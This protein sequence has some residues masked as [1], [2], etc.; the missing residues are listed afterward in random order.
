VIL[1][2]NRA[3]EIPDHIK[4]LIFDCDGT[5]VDS[6]SLHMEAWNDALQHFGGV[7]DHDFF[8]SKKG[9]K[10]EEIVTLYNFQY[11]TRY[12]P[13][14]IV[15]AKHIFFWRHIHGVKPIEKI[16]AVVNRFK[17]LLPLA[18]VSGGT[19]RTIHKE[20]QVIGIQD[21]FQTILTADDP[22]KQKPA[23]DMFFEAARRIA[24][25][26]VQCLV[27]E[28]GDLGLEGARSAGM[29]VFDVR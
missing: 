4:G 2:S 5:L 29:H 25:P 19:R 23:P 10:E 27:F 6:M 13:K 17:T 11:N 26:S 21:F 16:V 22:F 20:L 14:E 1:A 28:D 15:E 18:V 7:F 12:N 9:M 8:F 3:I 24:V